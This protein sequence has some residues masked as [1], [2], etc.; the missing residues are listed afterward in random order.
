[1]LEGRHSLTQTLRG[2]LLRRQRSWPPQTSGR[3]LRKAGLA[4]TDKLTGSQ[5]RSDLVRGK[6]KDLAA[7][8]EHLGWPVLQ[9][10]ALMWRVVNAM[11][12]LGMLLAP[13]K[14]V[15][16][17]QRTMLFVKTRCVLASGAR[18]MIKSA[19]EPG[20]IV[21]STARVSGGEGGEILMA[22]TH[23]GG[24]C[25]LRRSASAAAHVPLVTALTEFGWVRGGELNESLHREATLQNALAP[26]QRHSDFDARQTV[27]DVPGEIVS[28]HCDTLAACVS[29]LK[30]PV[31]SPSP[32]KATRLPCSS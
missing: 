19:S 9:H 12:E 29:H 24:T 27:R 6:V 14:S 22:L 23:S 18:Q 20:A 3:D 25:H 30:S 28:A 8:Q 4:A 10:K 17:E 11:V 1:M 31:S 16:A 13:G 15:G 21:P 7:S 2:P 32:C 5:R 26:H